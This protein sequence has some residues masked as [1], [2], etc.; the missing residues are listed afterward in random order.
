MNAQT[1][2][3]RVEESGKVIPFQR[4]LYA[5]GLVELFQPPN[6]ANLLIGGA[7]KNP[8]G[9]GVTAGA[10]GENHVLSTSSRY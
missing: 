7:G 2:E 3:I 5:D 9:P 8:D 4:A 10:K 6:R 1:Q